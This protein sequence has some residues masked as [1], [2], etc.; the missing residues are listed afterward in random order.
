MNKIMKNK[1]VTSLNRYI[2]TSCLLLLLGLTA[3]AQ[4]TNN[5]AG[6]LQPSLMGG[7]QQIGAAFE[8]ATNWGVGVGYLR[9]LT[10]NY[11]IATADVVYNVSGNVG[12]VV[13][14]EDLFGTGK[15]QIDSVKGGVS[16]SLPMH[17]LAF[18]GQPWA[19]NIEGTPFVSDCVASGNGGVG[20]LVITGIAFKTTTFANFKLEVTP[21]YENR[22]QSN[23]Y[24]RNF[25]GAMVFIVRDF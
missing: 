15:N 16:L 1:I 22:T 18:I 8:S 20:N 9:S 17:P 6:P 25:A 7:I 12:L 4:T 19:A 21:M 13:G 14:Y 10:G 5:T 3:G 24:G 11:N 23:A 2:V